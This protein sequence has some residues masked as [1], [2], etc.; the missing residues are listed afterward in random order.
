MHQVPPSPAPSPA[1]IYFKALTLTHLTSL[2]VLPPSPSLFPPSS[3]FLPTPPSLFLFL[4]LPQ[5]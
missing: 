4:S 5:I 2:R 3:L 1:T